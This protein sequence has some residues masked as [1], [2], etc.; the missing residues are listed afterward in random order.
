MIDLTYFTFRLGTT[1]Y[2]VE[3]QTVVEVFFLPEFTPVP[4]LPRYVV[5]VI[6]VRGVILPVIDLDLRLGQTPTPYQTSD[7][8][9][10]LAA[11]GQRFG[12]IVQDVYGIEQFAPA[13]IQTHLLAQGTDADATPFDQTAEPLQIGLAQREQDIVVL[14]ETDP[15]LAAPQQS[16]NLEL[17][18]KTLREPNP[19][20]IAAVRQTLEEETSLRSLTPFCPHATPAEQ[21]IFRNRAQQLAQTAEQDELALGQQTALAIVKLGTEW[22]GLPVAMIRE[23]TEIQHLTPIPA[24]PPHILGNTNLR[25]EIITLVDISAFLALPPLPSSDRWPAVIVNIE[26]VSL[27]IAVSVVLDIH[28]Y[29]PATQ[30]SMPLAVQGSARDM[31]EGAIDYQGTMVSRLNLPRLLAQEG[32]V[33]DFNVI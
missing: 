3:S 32:F 29:N 24:C 5:G 4:G 30:Q 21:E 22:F 17:A 23:F 14:L 33:V 6:N 15:M 1:T 25:G 7:R 18:L 28:R 16:P 31:I 12:I 19:E 8:V 27:G 11:R 20:A 26:G 2:G 10:L 9:I 13:Q